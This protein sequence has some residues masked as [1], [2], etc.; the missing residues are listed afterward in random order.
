MPFRRFFSCKAARFCAAFL[1]SGWLVT[2][3]GCASL[4]Q[5]ESLSAAQTR[6]QAAGYIAQSLTAGRF[7]LMIYQPAQPAPATRLTLYIEGDGAAWP[8][9]YHPPADPT[10]RHPVA[11]SL[12]LADPDAD[13]NADA[14]VIYLGRPC[15]YLGEPALA[16]CDARYWTGWR[17]APEVIAAYDQ[18]LDTLKQRYAARHLRLVGYSGGGVIAALLAARRSDIESLLTVAA[19]LALEDWRIRH[20]ISALTGSLDPLSQPPPAATLQGLHLSGERD[21]VVPPDIIATYAR[22]SGGTMLTVPGYNHECCWGRDWQRLLACLPP[23]EHKEPRDEQNLQNP[24]LL[25]HCLRAVR[26]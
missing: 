1:S 16:N 15:Q 17:F 6:A 14:T 3:S 12:A 7:Q 22:Y 23:Q 18:A 24:V 20:Q 8:G 5:V 9:P 10:P 13:T 21:N 25:D 26:Q 11:L 2:L 19:P 4:G